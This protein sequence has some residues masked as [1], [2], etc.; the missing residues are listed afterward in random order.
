MRQSKGRI[1]DGVLEEIFP[2]KLSRSRASE[3]AYSLLKQ[4]ILSGEF[5]KGQRLFREEIAQNF[6]VSET[7]VTRAFSRLKKDG[8]IIIK[9]GVGS[10]VA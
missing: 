2:K 4:Q 7:M 5:K 6:N 9:G 10:F 1:P 3:W 8:L